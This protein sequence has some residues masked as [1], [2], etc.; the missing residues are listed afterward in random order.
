[1]LLLAV[2]QAQDYEL[3]STAQIYG[4]LLKLERGMRVLYIAAHPDDE[5]TRLIAWL[6]NSQHIETAYLSLTRGEGGQN[7]IGDEQGDALGVLRTYEL[8]EARKI[9]GGEQ[10]FTRAIDFG[11][12]KSAEESFRFWGKDELLA[13]VVLA[14][15]T[16]RPQVIVTRFPPD[17]NA[18]HGH[19]EASALL[20]AEAFDLAADPKAFA[21]QLTVCEPWQATVLYQ[22]TSSWWRKELDAKTDAELSAG[23]IHKLN[24]GVFDPISALGVNEIAAMAR[25]KHR[26]Q[27]FGTPRSRGAQFEYLQFV[28]GKWSPS[29]FNDIETDWKQSP[30]HR[31]AIKE[32]VNLYSFTDPDKNIGLWKEYVAPKLMQRSMWAEAADMKG[33]QQK[34]NNIS[35]QLMAVRVEAFADKDPVVLGA[36]Y[37]I[38]IQVYNGGTKAVNVKFS[39]S[40]IDTAVSVEPGAQVEFKRTLKAP[41]EP[42]QPFWLAGKNGNLYSHKD[43]K[44]RTL[45][46]T[47]NHEITYVIEGA[48]RA[49][50]ATELHRRW[51]DRSVGEITQPMLFVPQVSVDL[52]TAELLVPKNASVPYSI[53][54]TANADLEAV[55]LSIGS[56][57]GNSQPEIAIGPMKKGQVITK[58]LNVQYDS[59]KASREMK[60]TA[61]SATASNATGMQVIKYEHVPELALFEPAIIQVKTLEIAPASGKILYIEGSGDKVDEALESIGYTVDRKNI[62]D[63][64]IEQM[65]EYKAVITGVR[66]FNTND[67]L[68]ANQNKLF[69]YAE[70]GGNVVVQYNTT[71]DLKVKQVA[72]YELKIG[73]SRVTEEDAEATAL[74]KNHAVFN[75]PNVIGKSDWEG[76]VQERGLY[77]AESWDSVQFTPLITWNDQGEEP[78]KGGLLLAKHGK[79]SY[80]YTGISFFRELPAGV[81]GAYRLLVNMIE[82][83]QK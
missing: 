26:C 61:K 41:D 2:G 62:R 4:D 22:N 49:N 40:E 13:D 81:P 71:F 48:L 9:D 39:Q 64:S 6:E 58:E 63:L 12:S 35:Q 8:L 70:Q 47:K 76:W 24:I 75:T 72:P 82:Y 46:K 33:I 17:R 60:F 52:S 29:L 1:M 27:A 11:Y 68:S 14:I 57:G 10:M 25:S 28:K 32:V 43:L 51:N 19:H 18:G 73:R 54:L 3:K 7:L 78:Q 31:Q 53:T 50:G 37:G 44:L 30:E 59:S 83:K 34:A 20:A 79:G 21:D 5:N 45:A 38:T 67:D 80:F 74:V 65:R 56:G 15:R 69:E 55:Q 42:N 36:E 66:A 77:F 23:K 16:F